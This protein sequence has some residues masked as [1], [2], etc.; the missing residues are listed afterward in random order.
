VKP[1]HRKGTAVGKNV[2]HILSFISGVS[3]L[4]PER[5]TDA[6]EVREDVELLDAY[7]RAVI[8]VVD[9]VGPSVV[10]VSAGIRKE[11]AA[12][13]EPQGS[14]SGVLLTPDGYAL[15]NDHVV[16]DARHFQITLTDGTS[17]TASLVGSDPATDLAVIRADGS[18]L[19]YSTLGDSSQLRAG[20]LVI[21]M[22]NP[23]GF[24]S[25]VS[26]GVVSALGRTL[27]SRDG[28]LIENIIQHTA[29]LN[30]GNS[31]GPLLDSAGRVVGINTAIIFMAQGIGFTIPSNTARWV[32]SQILTHGRVRRAY[33]GIAGRSRPIGRKLARYHGL[34]GESA[35][36]IISIE[37]DGPARK[38]GLHIGDVIISSNGV[39]VESIDDLHRFLS[40]WPVGDPVRLGVLRRAE[41]LD[42]E[43][44]PAEAD[45]SR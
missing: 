36:E 3:P 5:N 10:S 23:F 38:A 21:A 13:M 12:M 41:M 14:G 43:L 37:P 16:N 18:N 39:R 26:T 45:T 32:F 44:I 2:E 33:L 27:R 7:S 40:E 8:S 4:K 20:Q 28:R 1:E 29:P 35:V 25:T 17:T 30:P 19:P 24:Q 9:H 6:A 31:G 22:G 15:T 34:S 42:V 11:R